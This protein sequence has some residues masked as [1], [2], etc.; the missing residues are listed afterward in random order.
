M[1]IG[2][3]KEVKNRENRVSA[4]PGGV[5][6][7]TDAGHKVLIEKG[8]GLGAGIT[9]E[10]YMQAGA[11]MIES[12]DEVW[13]KADMIIKVKEPIQ[14]EFERMRDG[15]ILYISS[16]CRSSRIRSR[17]RETRSYSNRL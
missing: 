6:L 2:V 4:V 17:A 3:P 12:A 5:K 16:P 15:Q 14:E 9:D 7:F 13:A 11:T 1:I 8:A 10:A